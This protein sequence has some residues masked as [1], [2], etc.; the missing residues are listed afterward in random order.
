MI[1][2]FFEALEICEPNETDE[3]YKY[4]SNFTLFQSAKNSGR[5][6]DSYYTYVLLFKYEQQHANRSHMLSRLFNLAISAYK[7]EAVQHA[8]I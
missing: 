3:M 8:G 2:G 7:H 4:L 1:P 6:K 5:V